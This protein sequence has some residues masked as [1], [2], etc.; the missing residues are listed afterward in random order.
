MKS[1]D[2]TAEFVAIS[3][4]PNAFQL[5]SF[6]TSSTLSRPHVKVIQYIRQQ[7]GNDVPLR[8]ALADAS[9]AFERAHGPRNHHATSTTLLGLEALGTSRTSCRRSSISSENA[10]HCQ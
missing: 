10:G 7:L 2:R 1:L 8:R 9:T 3:R 5:F 4:S 6:A